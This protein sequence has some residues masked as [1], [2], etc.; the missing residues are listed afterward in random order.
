MQ[1]SDTAA[2][3]I[4][5]SVGRRNFVDI[6]NRKS[7][8]LGMSNTKFEGTD[9]LANN[10][11]TLG[12]MY[13]LLQYTYFKRAFLLKLTKGLPYTIY[14]GEHST[15]LTN[16]NPFA[17]NKKLVG[18]QKDVANTNGAMLSVWEISTPQGTVPVGIILAGS[19]NGA[20]DTK[21]LFDWLEKSATSQ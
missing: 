2:N 17:D 9:N 6:M 21:I 7:V 5:S 20:V 15:T 11:S 18:V 16:L 3:V 4:A 19:T 1:S 14:S 13:K 10:V 12:D 8:S